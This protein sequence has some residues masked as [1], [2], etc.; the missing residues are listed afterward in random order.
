MPYKVK[1]HL[2]KTKKGL[3]RVKEAERKSKAKKAL[4]IGASALTTLGL[5]ALAYKKLGRKALSTVTKTT[6]KYTPKN[7]AKLVTPDK[8]KT[9]PDPWLDEALTVSKSAKGVSVPK[10]EQKLLTG[11]KY[12]AETIPDPWLDENL[13]ISKPNK[14]VVAK[15]EQKLLSGKELPKYDAPEYKPAVRPKKGFIKEDGSDQNLKQA[16]TSQRTLVKREPKDIAKQLK[17]LELGEKNRAMTYS[18]AA[19]RAG[20]RRILA[21]NK[22]LAVISKRSPKTSKSKLMTIRGR[23]KESV[24]LGE[25]S[26][27]TLK[28]KVKVPETKTQ[29]PKSTKK[30][31][32][33]PKL[34]VAP[35]SSKEVLGTM[36]KSAAKSQG[37]KVMDEIIDKIIPSSKMVRSTIRDIQGRYNQV[38]RLADE[39]ENM[40]NKKMTRRDFLQTTIN[41]IVKELANKPKDASNIAK[42]IKNKVNPKVKLSKK[43]LKEQQRLQKLRTRSKGTIY[44]NIEGENAVYRDPQGLLDL[45][46][47]STK[48]TARWKSGNYKTRKYTDL[49]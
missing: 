29:I 39:L 4:V 48:K 47:Q 13:T 22:R 28:K 24:R 3:V 32:A 5:G 34:T 35:I 8:Y 46:I 7:A 1:E 16:I 11:S 23:A 37:K 14:L 10:Q 20:N 44:T 27:L 26:M 12:K 6:T 2:R 31:L 15:Q 33:D 17:E 36:T 41:K 25:S 49:K 21:A 40:G 43:Q 30:P 38:L 19:M 18:P 45:I 42:G 9:L